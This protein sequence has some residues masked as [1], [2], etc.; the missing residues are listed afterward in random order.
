M[1]IKHSTQQYIHVYVCVCVCV[2]VSYNFV[3]A[4]KK[5]ASFHGGSVN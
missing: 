1:K 4:V 2:C 3:Y 5:V